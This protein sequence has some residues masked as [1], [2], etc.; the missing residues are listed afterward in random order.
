MRLETN[1]QSFLWTHSRDHSLAGPAF[2]EVRWW[3]MKAWNT[4]CLVQSF[5]NCF[6][7]ICKLK[8]WWGIIDGPQPAVRSWLMGWHW[9]V[10]GMWGVCSEP[11]GIQREPPQSLDW[12]FPWA[13][14][15]REEVLGRGMQREAACARSC[16]HL[17]YQDSELSV[18]EVRSFRL[19]GDLYVTW[20]YCIWGL[21][22]VLSCRVLPK[23]S[24][25]LCPGGRED[26][27]R[28]DAVLSDYL[29][30]K[31]QRIKISPESHA[32]KRERLNSKCQPGEGLLPRKRIHTVL[33]SDQLEETQ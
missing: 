1:L 24:L 13:R 7:F 21:R 10:T 23:S 2:N 25:R 16:S 4:S 33:T 28:R 18:E 22:P 19:F 6:L 3:A 20:W 11:Y 27:S 31:L 32:G 30:N 9:T 26:N 17:L 14:P 12:L 15:Q 5:T 29:N 8:E